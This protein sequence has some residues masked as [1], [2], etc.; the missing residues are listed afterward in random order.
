MVDLTFRG[1][2]TG[3][4]RQLYTDETSPGDKMKIKMLHLAKA[5]APSPKSYQRIYQAATDTP[6]R[7]GE[8]YELP[9]EVLGFMG[10][11]PIKVDPLDTMGFKISE[12]QD[13]IRN[14]RREFTGGVFGLLAGG[15]KTP[16]DVIERYIASNRARF[17]V[18]KDMFKNI[19]AAEILGTDTGEMRREFKDRQISPR[20]YRN[21]DEGQFEPFYPSR[22]I[23]ARFREIAEDIGGYNPFVEA[24]ETLRELYQEFKDMSL[25]D[26]W[27]IPV[28][29]FIFEDES[30]D[31]SQQVPLP[32][33]PMPNVQPKTAQLNPITGLTRTESALLSPEEQVIARRT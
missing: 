24:R 27:D 29:E 13:G 14:A 33:T 22:D 11:R 19:R 23:Q 7:R 2:R 15:Q 4:G 5:L 20:S 3:D 10:F 17:N 21:L 6:G 28:E 30:F 32:Q 18:Q 26:P 1:G 31:V 16:N 12:Y 8:T 25:E 9:D